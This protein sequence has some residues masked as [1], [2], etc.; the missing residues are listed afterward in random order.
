[1]AKAIRLI[2]LL[3]I[4]A[5]LAIVLIMTRYAD[6]TGSLIRQAQTG[7]AEERLAAAQALAKQA[8]S[9]RAAEALGHLVQDE[10]VRVAVAAVEGLAQAK[11]ESALAHL[12]AAAEDG[13]HQVRQAAVLALGRS[14]GGTRTDVSLAHLAKVDAA[15]EVRA[16][17]IRALGERNARDRMGE[18]IDALDD[19]A[20]DVRREAAAVIRRLWKPA[21]AFQAEDA[22]D[23]RQKIVAA[24]RSEWEAAHQP[25]REPR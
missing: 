16:A 18:I 10:D 19:P 17:A 2:I 15:P 14:G 23:K 13:R 1:M 24:I 9:P 5:V 25:N 8:D 11:D 20:A 6:P 22:A 12:T 7:S 4:A 3:A 21:F